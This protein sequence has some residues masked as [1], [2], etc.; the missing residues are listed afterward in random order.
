MAYRG[1]LQW[2]NDRDMQAGMEQ[3]RS[4]LARR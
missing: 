1:K 3:L 2:E 4:T